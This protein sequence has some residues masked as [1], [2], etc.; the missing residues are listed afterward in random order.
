[1]PDETLDLDSIALEPQGNTHLTVGTEIEYPM[2]EL[3]ETTY[4]QPGRYSNFRAELLEYV[5]EMYGGFPDGEVGRDPTAGIEVRSFPMSPTELSRWFRESIDIISDLYPYEPTGYA[6]GRSASSFGLH[7]H[8]SNLSEETARSLY[9]LSSSAWFQP[10][11]CTSLVHSDSVQTYQ[12]FRDN[13]CRM[14][15]DASSTSSNDVVTRVNNQHWEWRLVEPME[16]DNF[17]LVMRFLEILKSD[18][19]RRAE[20]YA[21]TLVENAHENLTS[22]KRAKAIGLTERVT[23]ASIGNATI[24]RTPSPL[25]EESMEFWSDVRSEAYSPYI[26][27]VTMEGEEHTFNGSEFYAFF[28]ES[29]SDDEEFDAGGIEF[30]PKT[31]LHA[32]SLEPVDDEDT[33]QAVNEFVIENRTHVEDG[34]NPTKNEATE[35]LAKAMKSTNIAADGEGES[36]V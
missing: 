7:I 20:R 25:N 1:M 14:S 32:G 31:V 33:V 24:R 3:G 30:T 16:P 10:L 5:D 27:R 6:D 11:V 28:S 21:R 9:R 22:V 18:G 19:E 23:D 15:F 29:Y 17:A 2:S 13:Y 36:Y 4:T 34:D 35:A 26:Y 8:I 12:V